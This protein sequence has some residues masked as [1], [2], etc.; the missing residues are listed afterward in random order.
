MVIILPSECGLKWKAAS[1]IKKQ[2]ALVLI[3]NLRSAWPTVKIHLVVFFL[4]CLDNRFLEDFTDIVD[5]NIKLSKCGNN[6]I[7]QFLDF[8]DCQSFL[9]KQLTRWFCHICLECSGFAATL[10]NC[11]HSVIGPILRSCRIVMNRNSSTSFSHLSANQS[12]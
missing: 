1:L 5:S 12:P 8:C 7:K 3:A 6:L 9:G 4:G 2:A 11:F 10:F